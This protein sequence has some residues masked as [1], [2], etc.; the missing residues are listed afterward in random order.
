[1]KNIGN[2]VHFILRLLGIRQEDETKTQQKP[3]KGICDINLTAVM[4]KLMEPVPEGKGWSLDEAENAEKWYRRFL[5][6]C[7][8]Y[9]GA[10][11]VPN[12]PIDT[13]WHQ[14]ILDTRAYAKDCQ[15][16]F[17]YF[18]HHYPYFGLNGDAEQ[19]DDAFVD[20]NALYRTHFGEDCTTMHRVLAGTT[21]PSCSNIPTKCGTEDDR[22]KAMTTCNSGCG[23]LCGRVNKALGCSAP[24]VAEA[25][26]GG[27]TCNSCTVDQA[28]KFAH[29]MSCN[30]HGSGTGCQ[31]K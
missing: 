8:L 4:M 30:G 11:I 27:G 18:M 5:T 16:V 9:P 19:R 31:R 23:R 7:H 29:A 1:M 3:Q 2:F 14:H 13:F 10:P 22:A 21:P 20:T 24:C 26:S 28:D 15:E 6:L 25:C 17:G 12:L